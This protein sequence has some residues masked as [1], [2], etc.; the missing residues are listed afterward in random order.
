MQIS[1]ICECGQTGG[2]ETEPGTGSG[3]APHAYLPLWKFSRIQGGA[4]FV[5]LIYSGANWFP[6]LGSGGCCSDMF[7]APM[8]EV[9]YSYGPSPQNPLP[10][11]IPYPF[12]ALVLLR[13]VAVLSEI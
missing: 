13:S 7:K 2:T 12:A 3:H 11:A 4:S 8:A 5:F 9:N 1:K 6:Q 10:F